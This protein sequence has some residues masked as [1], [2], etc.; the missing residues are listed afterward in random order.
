MAE[1]RRQHN[2]NAK[3]WMFTLNNPAEDFETQLISKC[4]A[5]DAMVEYLVCQRE[6]APTTGTEHAQGFVIFTCR[7]TMSQ[8]KKFIER[9]HWEVTR[10]RLNKEP[11]A[12][13][14]KADTRKPGCEPTHWGT[15][16]EGG[17]GKSK[18]LE[19]V[20]RKIDD[21]APQSEI[22]EEHFSTWVRHNK[23]LQ[24]YSALKTK[25]RCHQ[26]EG[27]YI[28]G[29]TGVGKSRMAEAMAP[30][31]Q[32]FWK[33]RGDWWDGYDGHTHVILD[34]FYGWL[35]YDDM[36]RI[37][38]RYP[39]LVQVK[40]AQ[41]NFVAEKVIVTSNKLP[42]SYYPRVA[43]LPGGLSSLYRRFS[44]W[45]YLGSEVSIVARSYDEF[46]ENLD[47]HGVDIPALCARLQ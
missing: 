8:V 35:K 14:T 18:E 32:T 22:M 41:T 21:G 16:P 20:K 37:V 40:G 38:D 7:R 6:I 11:I 25:K 43:S 34:D 1:P 5:G 45:I 9:A 15:V 24:L 28:V 27:V 4:D 3:R 39:L 10:A 42:H 31:E 36:L 12:Y 29:D 2:G 19:A 13:C 26:T 23:A 47:R 44:K 30:P 46:L 17:Q 33:Q